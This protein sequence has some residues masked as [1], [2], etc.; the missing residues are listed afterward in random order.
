MA[1]GDSLASYSGSDDHVTDY[2]T[3][4]IAG[5]TTFLT[6][7]YIIVVNPLVLGEVITAEELGVASGMHLPLLAVTTILSAV[8]AMLVMGIYANRPFGLA[9][10]MGLNAFFVTVVFAPELGITW[11]T[12]LAAVF[13][14]GILFMLLTAVGAREYVINL[15]PEP[16]KAGVGPGIGLFLAIIGL[17][18]MRITA[19]DVNDLLSFNPIL[20]QDPVAVVSVLGI[21]LT[22]V[23]YAKGVRGAIVLGIVTTGI[24]GYLAAAVGFEVMD[25]AA[26]ART[27]NILASEGRNVAAAI[28][29]D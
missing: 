4:L 1:S 29:L 7:S 12:A 20:A 26:A 14:E 24:L 8:A 3:E 11:E 22:F 13:L 19:S 25:S 16:V 17:Q 2:S 23:L 15:F 18:Y 6:M 28:L 9:S 27:Y 21:L 10:G 5:L